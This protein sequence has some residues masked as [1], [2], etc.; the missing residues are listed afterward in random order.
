MTFWATNTATVWT[1]TTDEFSQPTFGA[2]ETIAATW[3]DGKGVQEDEFG[4]QFVPMATFFTPT[5][6]ER[7]SFIAKGDHTGVGDPA[8]VGAQE[9]RK[10]VEYDVSQFSAPPEYKVM[11]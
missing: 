8:S 1:K 3:S 6:V 11:T 4:K 5:K 9:V 7:G 10:V 2:P